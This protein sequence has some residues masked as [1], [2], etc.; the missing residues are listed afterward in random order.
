MNIIFFIGCIENDVK[1]SDVSVEID[2]QNL[3]LEYLDGPPLNLSEIEIVIYF[4]QNYSDFGN[5]RFQNISNMSF[6]YDKF[7]IITCY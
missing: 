4:D 5:P 2:G 6:R 3:I 1:N 7:Y